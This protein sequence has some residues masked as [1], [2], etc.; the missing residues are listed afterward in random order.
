MR[1]KWSVVASVVYGLALFC[2]SA[3][4]MFAFFD[5]QTASKSENRALADRPAFNRQT[6]FS[7]QYGPALETYVSDH[8]L[9]RET[10]VSV[11]IRMEKL[12]GKKMAIQI[13]SKK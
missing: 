8:V 2:L 4:V 13:V 6:W 3:C 7:G 5:T 10:L 12:V 11:A 1:K 9:A